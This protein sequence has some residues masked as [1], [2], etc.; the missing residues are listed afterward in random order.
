MDPLSL[1]PEH[2]FS[3]NSNRFAAKLT[4]DQRCSILALARHGV[5]RELI[6][7][8]FGID[9][10]TVAHISNDHSAKYKHVRAT[11]QQLGHDEFTARYLT[12]DVA[13]MVAEVAP[14]PPPERANPGMPSLDGVSKRANRLAGI[15]IVAAMEGMRKYPH[16]VEIA[17]RSGVDDMPDGWYY[18]DMTGDDPEGWYHNGEASLRTSSACYQA[19]TE[20]LM[21]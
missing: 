13:R 5:K 2:A 14:E 8:A 15:Q 6:A 1:L 18:R 21:D 9:S 19:L 7:Q 10:R 3:K 20:N 4:E 12:E 16:E 17:F 11:Y